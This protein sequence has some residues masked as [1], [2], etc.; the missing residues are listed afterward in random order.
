MRRLMVPAK[1]SRLS[2]HAG[3][4]IGS[5]LDLASTIEPAE[6]C[7]TSHP[8]TMDNVAKM[9][10]YR[11]QCPP[12][13]CSDACIEHVVWR[14]QSWSLPAG[15]GTPCLLPRCDARQTPSSHGLAHRLID[16][17]VF[18]RLWWVWCTES[19]VIHTRAHRVLRVWRGRSSTHAAR[20]STCATGAD[21]VGMKLQAPTLARYYVLW[22]GHRAL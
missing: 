15:V 8:P 16:S 9:Q 4:I 2:L 11:E 5:M 10:Q 7:R 19:S 6:L 3:P 21:K 20:F 17:C 22:C 1:R 13:R 14:Q 12:L 18:D